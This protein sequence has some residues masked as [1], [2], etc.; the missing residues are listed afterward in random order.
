I[1]RT[2]VI[3]TDVFESFMKRNNLRKPVRQ[4]LADERI[5]EYF[6]NAEMPEMVTDSLRSYLERID[7]PLS[8]RSSSQLEDAYYQPYAGLYRTYMIPNNHPDVSVRLEHLVTAIK[9]VYASTYFED[10]KMFSL[11]TSNQQSKESMAVIIQEVS[12]NQYGDYYYPTVS[13]VAQSYN[14]YPFS[15][16]KAEEGVAS[17]ALGLGKTVVDGEKC[18]RFSPKYPRSIPGFSTVDDILNN[19]QRSF[20]ALKTRNYT[21][22]LH[23][24]RDRNLERLDVSDA[25]D[26]FP[27]RSVAGTYVPD[28][29]R[30][31]DTWYANGPKVPTFARL[32]KYRDPDLPR[33]LSDL[34]ELG[35]KGFGCPV[36]IE[37]SVN[38]YL[39]KDRKTDFHFLQ[40]RPMFTGEERYGVQIGKEEIRNAFCRSSRALGNGINKKM[41]D[42]VYV[43]PES[44]KPEATCQIAEEI[45][46][47]NRRLLDN[48]RP[49][50]L[51]GPGRWGSSDRWLGIPVKWR[52]ISGV[53]AII[54][55]RNDNLNADSSQGSHF[56]H[57]IT[58]LGIHY[59]SVN[60][61]HRNSSGEPEEFFDWEWIASLPAATETPFIR[62]VR[63]E[64]PMM[65]KI[66]G[67]KSQCVIART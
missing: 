9:L 21:G 47:I 23:F 19:A 37:F 6:L 27:V 36:E 18:L 35:R 52:N 57:N 17:I 3:C 44:F 58:S 1:P 2:M 41:A 10:P 14:F 20:F 5:T 15:H 66:D 63:L 33:L 24:Q 7:Y 38:L 39:E 30:I 45:N 53:G 59:I 48:Q 56:F 46:K 49:Y 12:G 29:N 42:I 67:K 51:V 22:D 50:L 43:K 60:E 61:I 13:G 54:E 62:H 65:L 28:E 25:A 11:C 32:L 40:I 55:I 8:V 64:T 4:N 31:R 26:D 34:L 16:M